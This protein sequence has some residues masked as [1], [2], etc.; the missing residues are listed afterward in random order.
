M[1]SY[2]DDEV[3]EEEQKRTASYDP[4]YLAHLARP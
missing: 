1:A 2:G 3:A 4:G